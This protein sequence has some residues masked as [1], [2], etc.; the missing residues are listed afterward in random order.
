VTD[1]HNLTATVVLHGVACCSK[2]FIFT[3]LYMYTSL[4]SYCNS[5]VAVCCSVRCSVMTAY[6]NTCAAGCRWLLGMITKATLQHIATHC[7][8]QQHTAARRSTLQQT[9]IPAAGTHRRL[10]RHCNT[11]Q[12]T[13]THRNTLQTHHTCCGRTRAAQ[14]ALQHPT[15]HCNTLQHT[16]THCNT[17]Q[18]LLW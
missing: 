3:A 17:L 14:V 8:A 2:P 18:Y 12:H 9:T 4:T 13:A 16:A 7:N 11:P 1:I 10:K 15:T 6:R 5:C